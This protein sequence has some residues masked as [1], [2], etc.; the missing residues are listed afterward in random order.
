MNDT[1][2][3]DNASAMDRAIDYVSPIPSRVTKAAIWAFA[4]QQRERVKLKDGFQLPDLI[5]KNGGEIK[6]I[7]FFD[8]D[9]VD[10]III[11]PDGS[12]IIRLS[13]HT[14]VLRDNFTIA[15]E[16]G[17]KLIH[18][19]KVKARHPNSGMRATRRVD[20]SNQDLVRC[21]W[22]ANW[23]ASAFLMPSAQFRVAYQQ[24]IA[25]ETFGVTD[26]AVEVRAKT[27]GLK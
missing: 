27:L 14:G 22:E 18:W 5:S 3:L 16:L 10:A 21:E 6:Y 2:L 11:E 8:D 12:F 9:Q 26:A 7:D 13:S 15:H 25:S 17:H 23:F 1:D 24:G 20:E 19:P 4:E